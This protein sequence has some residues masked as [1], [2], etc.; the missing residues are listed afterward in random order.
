MPIK[1]DPH[2]SWPDHGDYL[3]NLYTPSAQPPKIH[4]L[5][6]QD[7]LDY[8]CQPSERKVIQ[9]AVVL[10]AAQLIKAGDTLN[11]E[12]I[13][14]NR[15]TYYKQGLSD[16]E[17]QA[18]CEIIDTAPLSHIVFLLS[19]KYTR[20]R[21]QDQELMQRLVK[22][23]ENIC[24]GDEE[25]TPQDKE[26]LTDVFSHVIDLVLN[27]SRFD[28]SMIS[29]CL[30][31][32]ALAFF[33]ASITERLLKHPSV[34]LFADRR[35]KNYCLIEHLI[36]NPNRKEC[37]Q[38]L[39]NDPYGRINWF[40]NL[41][42]KKY[43]FAYATVESPDW[44]TD[45]QKAP[46]WIKAYESMRMSIWGLIFYFKEFLEQSLSESKERLRQSICDILTLKPF[47]HP[48]IEAL[49]HKRKEL[50][51]VQRGEENSEKRRAFAA[52]ANEDELITA[53]I[54]FLYGGKFRNI[55]DITN[56]FHLLEIYQPA[57]LCNSK[58]LVTL[59]YLTSTWANIRYSLKIRIIK[60]PIELFNAC[61]E[62]M[63]KRGGTLALEAQ[64]LRLERAAKF[65]G[66]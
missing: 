23:V 66:H 6:L 51:A 59:Y 7:Y 60:S 42:Y 62:D 3:L 57:F 14:S 49:R 11:C 13:Y 47:T 46:E 8:Q 4:I 55:K 40:E 52:R 50:Y 38:A 64:A 24:R 31:Y 27:D 53:V 39:F 56:L 2:L 45:F 9:E 19:V 33:P 22:R 35:D 18:L 20:A 63:E 16:E 44:L 30:L 15:G 36:N 17:Y 25:A 37:L 54:D 5:S 1:L 29:H 26:S 48:L 65:A 12:V 28:S 43:L 32:I 21:S 34:L 10:S 58:C 61:V 41:E